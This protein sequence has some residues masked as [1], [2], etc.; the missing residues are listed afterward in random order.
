MK[1]GRS[2]LVLASLA[3]AA[4]TLNGCAP[5]TPE[6]R[7]ARLLAFAS[8]PPVR[9]FVQRVG[10]ERVQAEALVKPG[11][12]PHAFDPT[13]RQMAS[14]AR[15][16]LL[17]LSGFPFEDALVPR[18]KDAMPDLDIVDTRQGIA[19][20][21]Q[22]EH[23]EEGEEGEAHAEEEG[24]PDPHVWMSP[25]LAVR[26]AQ[27]IRDALIRADPAGQESY[28][29]NYERFASE[30]QEVDRQLAEALAPLRG[31]ELLV[32]HPAFGYFAE[33]YGLKQVAVQ[34]GGKEPTARQLARLIEL[35]RERGVRVVFVQP[36]FSQAGAR[37]VAE[38]IGGAVVPLDDLPSDYLAN[39][40]EMSAKIQE[41]L[42]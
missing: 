34:T 36:Q 5:K 1:D 10:G 32:Y 24:G 4:L 13:P 17:F 23:E 18:L 37:S 22:E 30:L 41:A 20:R 3:L 7:G 12:E 35:A 8:I 28:Q 16:R 26:Q 27:T 42:R 6:A 29:A 11:Q 33:D 19:L 40:R 9:Y 31:K 39:L 2:T 25:R 38:A 14:L 15:A 21:M